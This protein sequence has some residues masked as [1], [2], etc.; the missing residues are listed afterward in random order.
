MLYGQ[1][2]P[3]LELLR[4]KFIYNADLFHNCPL[5]QKVSEFDSDVQLQF[6][7]SIM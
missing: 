3:E 4:N 7:V 6:H 1:V 5:I 2:I